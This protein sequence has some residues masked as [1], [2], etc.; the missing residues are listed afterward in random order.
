MKLIIDRLSRIFSNKINYKNITLVVFVLLSF[1]V[2]IKDVSASIDSLSLRL[3]GRILLQIQQHG[4]AWYVNPTDLRRY[5]M[6]NGADAYQMMRE[7]GLGITNIDLEKAQNGDQKIL[8]RIKGRIV[9][10]VEEHGE[11]FYINPDT[12]AVTYMKDGE[13]AYSIMRFQSLG[14]T[15]ENLSKI[16]IGDLSNLQLTKLTEDGD[17]QNENPSDIATEADLY[18]VTHVVDGDTFKIMLN[19]KEESVRLIG[20]DTPETVDPRTTVQCFGVEASNKA[21]ELLTGEKVRIEIDSTQGER[22]KYDR[23]LG[24]VYLENGE[25]FNKIMISEGYAYEYTYQSAYKYQEE[26]K[27]A[28]EDAKA[29]EKGLWAVG[30]CL[31]ITQ[32]ESSLIPTSTL[33]AP[34][35]EYL[36][37]T[38]SYYTAKYYYCETDVTWQGLSET[39]LKTFTSVD[40][41]LSAYPGRTLHEPCN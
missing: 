16:T 40:E 19:G 36:Y 30:A 35:G 41:L 3:Q 39:Y 33:D 20:V 24:Y 34:V 1:I 11:A 38:S 25:L 28:E 32:P 27:K 31:S 29:A 10:Q 17:I 21:K 4:E 14:I 2:P 13:V 8:N 18:M 37:Y 12:L 26:F 9:L 5:Y 6:K 15:D 23:L 22:D 7:F